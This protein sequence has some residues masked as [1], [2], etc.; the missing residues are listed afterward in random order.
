MGWR[1]RA[2]AVA[3]LWMLAAV[4]AAAAQD[5]DQDELERAFPIVEPDHGH[6]KLRLAKEGLEAIKRIETPIAAVAVIGPYRSGKSFLL[7]Q[8]LSLTCNKGIW[9]W[10]TPIELDVNG[11]KVSVLYLDT[12]GFESIGKSN[13]YDDRIFA[14]ATVL[15]SILIYNL[16][17]TI[18]EADISRLSFAV[19]IAEE[20]YGRGKMLLLSQQNYCGLSRGISSKE[21]LSSKWLM[22]LSNGCLTTMVN[23]IRDSLAFMGDNSTAF[24]LPQPHLQ[25][26]K[27]CDMD[28]Q[29]LD[30]L[31]IERRDEL[32]QIVTSMIKPKLV[33][34]RTLNGKEFVSF[35]RQI[36]EALNKGEIPSTGSLVEVFNKAILERCL[37]LYNERMERV[38]LPVSVDK[39]QLIHNLAEDEAR[40]LF[41]K[42]HF[43]KHHTTRSILKLDEEMRKVFGNF[44][45]ANEY[46]SSKLCEAKFSEC[47]DKM[48][49]LQSL[50]LPSMAKF[51]AGFLRCNQS[52]EMECVGPAKESYERRMSKMLARSRALF[53]KEYNN[54]LFNWLVTFSLVMIV[55]ARFVIKFF[56]LEVAAWVIFIFL[57]TYTRL[58]WSSELLYYNPIWHM[59]VSSWETIVY[60]PMGD[61][62]CCCAIIFSCLLALPRCQET[63]RKII[64]S[65]VQRFLRK[66]QSPKNRLIQV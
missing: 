45:F 48:E 8:L 28:D 2:S 62:N 51:N 3:V 55:I 14:L 9:V 32:K 43:G 34:G 37:K 36:L 22:K 44:G 27:L 42:Q 52:F 59:I 25:R 10:G 33:Q 31:Y 66:L 16:P 39:L 5:P 29:E 19:E 24:S 54:K 18:R 1:S 56:L 46:Q 11:S 65:F 15:S 50:K 4:V 38:G 30:P 40:K 20:F 64:A 53:I 58:F 63:N 41:D 12:E 23:R 57:E 35:L 49:H 60:N 21:N 61:P 6:T 26:T 17:E 13:V 7:N 47:E